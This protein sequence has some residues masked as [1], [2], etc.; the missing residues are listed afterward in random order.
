M[1]RWMDIWIEECTEHIMAVPKWFLFFKDS[2]LLMKYLFLIVCTICIFFLCVWLQPR[3]I[4]V[5]RPG[6]EPAP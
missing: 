3:H 1:H 4:E 6:I 5:P 2:K